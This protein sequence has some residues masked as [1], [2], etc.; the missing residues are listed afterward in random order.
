MELIID[1]IM[2]ENLL[3]KFFCNSLIIILSLLLSNSLK[4]VLY[5]VSVYKLI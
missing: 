3:G 2:S 1:G 5:I 4:L